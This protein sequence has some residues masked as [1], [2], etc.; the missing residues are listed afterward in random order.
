MF[1]R[2]LLATVFFVIGVRIHSMVEQLKTRMDPYRGIKQKASAK[3]SAFS[4][5]ELHDH[6]LA[7]SNNKQSKPTVTL[8]LGASGAGKG[9]Y[10]KQYLS[11]LDLPLHGLDEYL[12]FSKEYKT[13]FEDEYFIYESAAEECYPSIINLAKKRL[14]D[15]I[16]LNAS[17]VYEETG[18]DQKR[19]SK[20]VNRFR[21]AGY[22][23]DAV[24]VRSNI[25]TSVIRAKT[26]F[27]ETGRF[28]SEEY[29][30]ASEPFPLIK[31]TLIS[32]GVRTVTECQNDCM[33]SIT[34]FGVTAVSAAIQFDCL[35]CSNRL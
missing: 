8:L 18:K 19:M 16:R 11:G 35:V 30:R 32:L 33:Q 5:H 2:I 29:V 12:V 7:S 26:R 34:N 3:C 17:F 24:I 13:L 22:E 23:I 25:N 6:K 14:D 9:Q 31:P 27:L 10:Y 28:A 20:L 21:D 4:D 1:A 15:L